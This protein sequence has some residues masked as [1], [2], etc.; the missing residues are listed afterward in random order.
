MCYAQVMLQTLAMSLLRLTLPAILCF[1]PGLAASQADA[2][3]ETFNR[4]LETATR[5]MDNPATLALWENDGV[6][7]L[8]SIKPI[9]GKEAIAQFFADVLAQHPGGV[10][11]TFELQCF[12]IEV[13][14]AW[15]SEWCT[16]HQ[17]VAMPGGKA[18]FEGWGKML[19]VLHRGPDGRFR[20]ARE[21]WNQA[22]PPAAK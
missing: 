19:L 13:S 16:E 11:K 12:D 7:L 1:A 15:A 3:I 10:M 14:G 22:V 6:S 5:G 9:K 4:A 21:M 8:P 17:I 2:A 20:L 18:P